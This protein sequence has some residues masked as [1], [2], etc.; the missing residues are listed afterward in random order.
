MMGQCSSPKPAFSPVKA[1]VCHQSQTDALSKNPFSSLYSSFAQAGMAS[2]PDG[3]QANQSMDMSS[4]L[5]NI[6]P[7]PNL[8]QL[9]YNP[10][11]T[12]PVTV[13]Q[14][15]HEDLPPSQQE[16]RGEF[17]KADNNRIQGGLKKH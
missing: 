8:E 6:Y 14:S 9:F 10:S 15:A 4:P 5:Q 12:G 3:S 7:D 2:G 13:S 11:T 1:Q 16:K 17:S